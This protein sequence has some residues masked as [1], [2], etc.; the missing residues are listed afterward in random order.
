MQLE[1]DYVSDDAT[2]RRIESGAEFIEFNPDS[3][4]SEPQE[5]KFG[6]ELCMM[7]KG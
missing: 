1:C 4:V 5:F 6:S 2:R 7:V 3:A